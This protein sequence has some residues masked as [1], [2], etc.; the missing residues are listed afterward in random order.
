MWQACLSMFIWNLESCFVSILRKSSSI[1]GN[2]MDILIG[3]LTG[4]I[5][6]VFKRAFL[7]GRPIKLVS[8]NQKTAPTWKPQKWTWY[9]WI[10]C[11]CPSSPWYSGLSKQIYG[12]YVWRLGIS[13]FS[14]FWLK[15]FEG[16]FR[17]SQVNFEKDIH[18]QIIEF[19]ALD[20]RYQKPNVIER[21]DIGFPQGLGW[22]SNRY[23]QLDL[24]LVNTRLTDA[25]WRHQFETI[26][27]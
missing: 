15:I 16:I 4:S 20:M 23:F 5:S 6:L 8:I 25:S 10:H 18:R 7:I 3:D 14:I 27:R 1:D 13:I 26:L 22:V 17:E 19:Q 21:T 9:K 2:S 24:G 12:F 11:S